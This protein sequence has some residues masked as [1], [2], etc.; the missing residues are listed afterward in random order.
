MLIRDRVGEE[1]LRAIEEVKDSQVE[2]VKLTDNEDFLGAIISKIKSEI[3]VLETTKSVDA[4]A[5][6]ME[7]VDWIQVCFGTT[8]MN[9]LIDNRKEKLGLYWERYYIKENKKE[10]K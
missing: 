10:Q 4:L 8:K 3:E 9:E 2:I 1:L 6:I 5:E 7:L